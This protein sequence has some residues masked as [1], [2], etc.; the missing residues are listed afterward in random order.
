VTNAKVALIFHGYSGSRVLTGDFPD[1]TEKDQSFRIA[2]DTLGGYLTTEQYQ[3][4]IYQS[5]TK[6]IIERTITAAAEK[7]I[8]ELHIFCHGDP[9]GLSLA[10]GYQRGARALEQATM[11][12]QYPATDFGA[13]KRALREEDAILSGWGSFALTPDELRALRSKFADG[14]LIQ[15]WACF[16]GEFE[17]RFGSHPNP[18]LRTYFLRFNR[19]LPKVPGIARD[20]A[21]SFGLDCTASQSDGSFGLEFWH[22]GPT[23]KIV[24]NTSGVRAKAPFWLWPVKGAVWKTYKPDGTLNANSIRMPGGRSFQPTATEVR[25]G[26]PPKWLTGL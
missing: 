14:A 4:S 21:M 1:G 2:A 15:I 7:S 10:Y 16:T 8:A 9:I 23:A 22:R 20:L 13:T 6:S 3:V 12:N 24:L 25:P 5:W 26:M 18:T 17:W 11:Y 19:T